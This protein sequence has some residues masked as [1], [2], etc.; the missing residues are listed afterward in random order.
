[1][2]NRCGPFTP[3]ST[4]LCVSHLLRHL[5]ATLFPLALLAC[6]DGPAPVPPSVL[7][8]ASAWSGG[9][10]DPVC[11]NRGPR[12]EYLGPLPGAEHCQW[13]TVTRGRE[14]G[15]VFA[16]RDSANGWTGVTWERVFVDTARVQVMLDSL[17]ASFVASGLFAHRCSTGGRRWQAPGLVVQ[18][19]PP[20]PRP[21]GGFVVSV[22]VTKWEA[23]VP[24]LFCPDAPPVTDPAP[25]A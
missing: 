9:R 18:T 7:E 23:A 22:I 24:T 3:R 14:F 15:T 11:G 13:P 8:L 25:R 10:S 5:R 16:T 6:G 12:G 2:Q 19:M 20:T 17:D 4:R 21:A 1:M